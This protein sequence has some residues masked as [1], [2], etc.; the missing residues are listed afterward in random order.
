M[1][2]DIDELEAKLI[3]RYG[4]EKWEKNLM[5]FINEAI[6]KILIMQEKR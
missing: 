5:I 4:E 3:E 1:K 2:L 6:A